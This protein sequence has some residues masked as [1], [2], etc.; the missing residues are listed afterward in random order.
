VSTNVSFAKGA[1]RYLSPI[2]YAVDII[3]II[4]VARPGPE[5]LICGLVAGGEV[6]VQPAQAAHKPAGAPM[7]SVLHLHS[8]LSPSFTYEAHLI[9]GDTLLP[10]QPPE[11]YQVSSPAT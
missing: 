6:C 2:A 5:V 4:L 9:Q 11:S 10:V 7:S 3:G 1:M 8:A